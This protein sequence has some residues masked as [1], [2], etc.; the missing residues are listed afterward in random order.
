MEDSVN[1][2][3]KKVINE[4]GINQTE[5]GRRVGIKSGHMTQLLT[6]SKTLST[7]IL[8]NIKNTFPEVNLD[9]LV[10]GIGEVLNKAGTIVKQTDTDLDIRIFIEKLEEDIRSMR[11]KIEQHRKVISILKKSLS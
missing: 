8:E 9:Y 4:I 10:G 3:L 6:T 11:T 7:D 1:E 5:F 2:R